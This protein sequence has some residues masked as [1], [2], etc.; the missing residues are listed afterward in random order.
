MEPV[1][2]Q[3]IAL[4]T[5]ATSGIG[6]AT[7]ELFCKHGI[8][9]IACGRRADRL[10][11]LKQ[12]MVGHAPV[13]PLAFDVVDYKSI[14][15]EIATLPAAWRT[16]NILINN[17][18]NAHG[19]DPVQKGKL[20]DWD[21]MIDI[22][23][24]GLL[25]VTKAVL[26]LMPRNKDSV[27]VNIGSIAAKEAYPNGNVYCS[28]K[29]AVDH[30]TKAMRHDLFKEGIRV[31][32]LHPGLVNTE[33]SLVRFKGDKDKA[34]KV[35]DGC[36]ALTAEDCADSILFM[37]TRPAHVNIADLLILPTDQASVRDVH[38]VSKL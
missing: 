11:N 6:L 1:K 4:V 33:F 2:G 32:A 5:G 29:A 31:A 13:Y 20:S 16:V 7:A 34:D 26:P 14:E 24:K 19:L 27:V 30:L 35:Y 38:R 37:V 10:E 22:N 28:T 17:A 9:V 15:K 12:K 18:G 8:A 23:F 36:R 3:R 25:Y 21:A